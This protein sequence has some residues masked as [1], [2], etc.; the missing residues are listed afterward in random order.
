MKEEQ[1]NCNGFCE[2]HQRK[3]EE[4]WANEFECRQCFEDYHL[5]VTSV[6]ERSN[7]GYAY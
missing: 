7:D 2:L 4:L 1:D 5:H 3:Y 6:L